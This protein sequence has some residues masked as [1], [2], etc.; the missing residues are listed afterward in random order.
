MQCLYCMW[1]GGPVKKSP[2]STSGCTAYEGPL[3]ACNSLIMI[4]WMRCRWPIISRLITAKHIRA[5]FTR[6]AGSQQLP[7]SNC[8]DAV[9]MAKYSA[10]YQPRM[11]FRCSLSEPWPTN[12]GPQ[13][14][15]R[16]PLWK[17][18][19]GSGFTQR[20]LR[21]QACVIQIKHVSPV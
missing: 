8:L 6:A 5:C 12:P 21:Q 1:P 10:A 20:T 3:A 15:R 7:D 18:V 17:W 19:S 16:Y 2:A 4:S 11:L 13:I 9:T 14:R